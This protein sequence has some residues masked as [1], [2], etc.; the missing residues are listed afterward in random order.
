MFF[1]CYQ[2]YL[3]QKKFESQNAKWGLATMIKALARMSLS[4][5]IKRMNV[6]YQIHKLE[7]YFLKKIT[8]FY[9]KKLQR[10]KCW[11]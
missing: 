4:I 10:K 11:L 2:A 6:P 1:P 5:A 9:L 8:N 7:N 3:N